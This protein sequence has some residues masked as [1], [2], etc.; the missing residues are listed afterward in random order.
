MLGLKIENRRALSRAESSARVPGIAFAEW[1]PT[2]MSWSL[3][4]VQATAPPYPGELLAARARVMAA[5]KEAGLF[6][7]NRA[8][9]DDLAAML[10]EGVK[11]LDPRGDEE[12]ARAGRARTGRTMRV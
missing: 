11:I 2:D 1:G 7:L 8:S 6:F 3:G 4:H 9:L 12:V 10:G 5:A